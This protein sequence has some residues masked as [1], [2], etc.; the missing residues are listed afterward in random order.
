MIASEQTLQSLARLDPDFPTF[1]AA[2]SPELLS[3]GKVLPH[4]LTENINANALRMQIL[5]EKCV[6][7]AILVVKMR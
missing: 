1:A 7:N 3:T 6:E 2:L 5:Q 4:G